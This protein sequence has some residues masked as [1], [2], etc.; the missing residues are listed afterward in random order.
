MNNIIAYDVETTI[1]E[2]GSIYSQSNK[3][4]YAGFYKDE[5]EYSLLPIEYEDY[6]YGI[7]LKKSQDIIDKADLIVGFNLKFDIGWGKR[8]GLNFSNSRIWDCQLV[9]FILQGQTDSYPSLNSVS[10]Y[11]GIGSKLDEVKAYWEAGIDTPD[12][13]KD[14]LEQYLKQDIKLTLEVYK[15]QVEEVNQKSLA[16]QRLVSLHNQDLLVLQEIE[17]NG[18]LFDE[19]AC[20]RQASIEQVNINELR[21]SLYSSHSIPEFNTESGDHLQLCYMVVLLPLLEKSL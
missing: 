10:E 9:H 19:D 18:L 5:T 16:F 7:S 15:K 8:Y 4:V 21:A 1:Y 12:I 3:L 6:P 14:V 17:Y 11:Y 20:L 13:P 2:K